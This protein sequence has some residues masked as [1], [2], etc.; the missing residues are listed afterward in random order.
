M[1]IKDNGIGFKED[2]AKQIFNIFQRLEGK[3]FEGSGIGLS[4]CQRIANRHGGQIIVE[5]EPGKGSNFIIKL[6][7]Q[8][9]N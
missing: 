3:R 9:T 5:S 7:T 8:Q 2:Y 4:V 6:A 1:S